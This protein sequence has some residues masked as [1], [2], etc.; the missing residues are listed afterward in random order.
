MFPRN[1]C[2]R[3]SSAGFFFNLTG[4]FCGSAC[5]F[6]LSKTKS[7][8]WLT[9]A[10]QPTS[11]REIQLTHTAIE[12]PVMSMGAPQSPEQSPSG[13]SFVFF[14]RTY[15]DV[16]TRLG[17]TLRI[18]KSCPLVPETWAAPRGC[19]A[20]RHDWTGCCAAWSLNIFGPVAPKK[21]GVAPP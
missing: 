2:V 6:S 13:S 17:K 5:V 3:E 14:S 1:S 16:K 19:D 20:V 7:V 4:L 9:L 12:K 11:N 10:T 21:T 8:S 15:Y 18:L